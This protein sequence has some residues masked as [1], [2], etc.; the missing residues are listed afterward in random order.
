MVLYHTNFTFNNLQTHF[1]GVEIFF[2]ISGFL[3]SKVSRKKTPKQ[4]LLGRIVRIIP[5]YWLATA[6][7]LTTLKMW[8]YWPN[9]HVVFSFLFIPHRSI[10]GLY[11]VLGV[12]WTLNIEMYCYFIFFLCILINRK[13]APIICAVFIVVIQEILLI[14]FNS[15]IVNSSYAHHNVDFFVLGI[16]IWYLSSSQTI[17]K[18]ISLVP[19]RIFI[20]TVLSYPLI[21]IYTG[22]N[23]NMEV[24]VLCIIAILVKPT[25]QIRINSVLVVLGDASYSC[26]LLQ[27]ILIEWLRAKHILPNSILY[28]TIILVSSWVIAVFWNQTLEKPLTR[29]LQKLFNI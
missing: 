7:L 25:K 20:L 5:N 16:L 1:H 12:G 21:Y 29:K 4:F 6:L 23:K 24:G 9:Q 13:Y 27:T 11:P 8:G 28:S 10:P 3:I 18:S 17:T 15:E 19:P 26:Y 14:Y 22:F 2:V